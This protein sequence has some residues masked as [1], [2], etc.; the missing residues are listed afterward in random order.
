M[1]AIRVSPL[2]DR[3]EPLGP[4]WSEVNGMATPLLFSTPGFSN[5]A[6]ISNPAR[7]PDPGEPSLA[8]TDL[9]AL[10]RAG[11]KGPGAA[12]WLHARAVPVPQQPNTWSPLDGGGLVARLGRTEFLIEDGLRGDTAST[13]RTELGAGA[14]GVYAVLRQDAAL[15]VRGAAL[16]ELF[17]QTCNVNFAA[18]PPQERA[19]TLTMMVG[20][21]VTVIDTSLDG[22][23]TYRI[24]CDGTL[25]VYLWD[26]LLE[27]AAE[28]GGGPVG[29]ATALPEAA[30]R[31][32][33][34]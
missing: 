4:L 25:G 7:F 15:L 32:G 6:R 33:R 8:L 17:A 24:W 12:D 34:Q 29:L 28:L 20:V 27:I 26:T 21:A 9:S 11:L 23:P 14:P 31:L 2:H 30:D 1:S 3:L 22:D 16:H 18:I 10:Q 5:P 19:A 13:L